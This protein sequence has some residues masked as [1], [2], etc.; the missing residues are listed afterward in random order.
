MLL[1]AVAALQLVAAAVVVTEVIAVALV[2]VMLA[3][4]GLASTDSRLSDP[5]AV[6]VALP[7][8][9]KINS[10]NNVHGCSRIAA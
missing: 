9:V 5:L 8:S 10:D 3:A 4:V 2:I 1:G 7:G 6:A